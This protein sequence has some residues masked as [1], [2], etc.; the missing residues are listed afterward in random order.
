[1]KVLIVLSLAACACVSAMDIGSGGVYDSPM[2]TDYYVRQYGFLFGGGRSGLLGVRAMQ[3][4]QDRFHQ[5]RVPTLQRRLKEVSVNRKTVEL[6]PLM[7]K[8]KAAA[9]PLMFHRYRAV[10]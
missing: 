7:V 6:E 5:L 8:T 3:E 10:P 2:A 4:S 9:K 1:M